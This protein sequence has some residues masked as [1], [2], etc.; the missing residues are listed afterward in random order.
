MHHV[1][2]ILDDDLFSIPD[3]FQSLLA[4]VASGLMAL[5]AVH[6]ENG[7]GDATEKFDGLGRVEGLW[8]RGAMQRVKFPD[9]LSCRR[10]LHA[11]AGEM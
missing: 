6:D 9:P 3:F 4:G 7:T 10:L 8:R 1:A 2:C 5:C 11:G